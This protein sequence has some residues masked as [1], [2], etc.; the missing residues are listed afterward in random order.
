MQVLEGM[1]V[2][3][4]H[5]LTNASYTAFTVF[6]M[7]TIILITTT[8]VISNRQVHLGRDQIS[9]TDREDILAYRAEALSEYHVRH[10]KS[11][12]LSWHCG[13]LILPCVFLCTASVL[14]PPPPK[15]INHCL[16]IVLVFREEFQPSQT[17]HFD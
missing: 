13:K 6:A 16:S 12:L 11:I 14:H 5:L 17:L 1:T 15:K 2:C 10:W 9:E 8:I 4:S 7:I 3:C